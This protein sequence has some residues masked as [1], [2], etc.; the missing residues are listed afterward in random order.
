MG[1]RAVNK[2]QRDLEARLRCSFFENSNRL[3]AAQNKEP[4]NPSKKY[5]ELDGGV[6]RYGTHKKSVWPNLAKFL[7]SRDCTDAE[8]FIAAAFSSGREPLINTIASG[9][10]WQVYNRQLPQRKESI[11]GRLMSDIAMLDTAIM[12]TKGWFPRYT[13]PELVHHVLLNDLFHI[14]QLFRYCVATIA[15]LSDVVDL[16]ELSAAQQYLQDPTLYDDIWGTKIPASIRDVAVQIVY[17]HREK[18]DDYVY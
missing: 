5:A 8:G 16:Y 13:H 12:E 1:M 6:T 18:D 11:Y 4:R 10:T 17:I 15:K 7:L 3:S 14:S 9:A 2:E